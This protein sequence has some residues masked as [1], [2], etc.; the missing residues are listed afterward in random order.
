MLTYLTA[1]QVSEG[2][3]KSDRFTAHAG[4]GMGRVGVVDVQ[5]RAVVD[6]PAGIRVRSGRDTLP[7][8]WAD[9]R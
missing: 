7:K 9:R 2:Y 4:Q 5:V 8:G 6:E 1:N 3:R